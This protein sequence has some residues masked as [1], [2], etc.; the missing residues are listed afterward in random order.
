[1]Y[2]TGSHRRAPVR[3][4]EGK[5]DRRVDPAQGAKSAGRH[6]NIVHEGP[7]PEK[8]VLEIRFEQGRKGGRGRQ[9]THHNI[10]IKGIQEG[11][12]PFLSKNV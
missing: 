11:F 7:S 4:T 6:P 8:I 9:D 2:L 3:R 5:Y 10:G 1:V 12:R